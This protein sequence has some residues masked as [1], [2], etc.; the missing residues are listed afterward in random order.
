MLIITEKRCRKCGIV[1]PISDFY[2]LKANLVDGYRYRCKQCDREYKQ[3]HKEQNVRY[4]QKHKTEISKYSK[5]HYR[6]NTEEI[7]KYSR[8]YYKNH[9]E[10]RH[11]KDKIFRD[12]HKAE[13]RVYDVKYYWGN[14]DKEL[15]RC[16]EYRLNHR[17]QGL[18]RSKRWISQLKLEVLTHYGDDKCACVK[19][20][21]DGH[22]S[23]L[24]IDHIGGNGWQHRNSLS[25]TKF[26]NWLKTNGYP[27]G[28][29]TL[30]MNCQFIKRVENNEYFTHDKSQ[31]AEYFK[32][33]RQSYKSDVLTHYGEGECKCIKCGYNDL[34]ALSIDHINGKGSL[35]RISIKRTNIYRWL[36]KNNYPEGYQTLCMN[37][38]WVKRETN[39]ELKKNSSV[40]KSKIAA[41]VES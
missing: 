29:Q 32:Q 16:E 21:Y 28:F 10:E 26:Y 40:V 39:E 36:K 14:R 8:E 34:R 25:T 17:Q 19:C 3:T 24:S 9:K 18:D 5:N 37:C 1:K 7:L 13:R 12:K 35:H 31:R 22:M 11:E 41:F 27:S 30:C 38:Q 2:P 6:K 15:K 33:Y 4:Y 20:G 23:A